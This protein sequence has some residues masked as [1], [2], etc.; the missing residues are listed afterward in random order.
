MLE[1]K[2]TFNNARFHDVIAV[3]VKIRICRVMTA[4]AVVMGLLAVCIQDAQD[5]YRP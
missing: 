3:V 5:E 2:T 1:Q 4:G